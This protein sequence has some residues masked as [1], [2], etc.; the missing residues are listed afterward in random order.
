MAFCWRSW[1]T[2]LLSMPPGTWNCS[3]FTSTGAMPAS[4]LAYF[5]RTSPMRRASSARRAR[6]SPVSRGVPFSA[7]TRV[8]VGGWL[9][10]MAMPQT[11]QAFLYQQDVSFDGLVIKLEDQLLEKQSLRHFLGSTQHHPRWAIA[12]K[13]PAEQIVTQIV[14][15]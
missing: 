9:V 10:L 15:L 4:K 2:M 12:Y 1:L 7:A 8:S 3:T 6:S 14:S 13:Y 5:R 11:L